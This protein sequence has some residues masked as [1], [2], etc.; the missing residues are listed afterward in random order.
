MF[1]CNNCVR[2]IIFMQDGFSPCWTPHN[3]NMITAARGNIDLIPYFLK[4]PQGNGWRAPAV[5]SE[6]RQRIFSLIDAENGLVHGHIFRGARVRKRN[7]SPHHQSGSITLRFL[8]YEI[9][10]LPRIQKVVKLFYILDFNN[11][12]P[13]RIVRVT[14]DNADIIQYIFVYVYYLAADR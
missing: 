3:V 14:V 4:I 7:Y 9:V 11:D 6:S 5:C 13:S 1:F 2:Q 12:H 8:D 10:V